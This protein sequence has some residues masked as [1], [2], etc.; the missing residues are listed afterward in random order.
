MPWFQTWFTTYLAARLAPADV[1]A[2]LATVPT[3]TSGRMLLINGNITEWISYT[4]VSGSTITGLTRNLSTTADPV[5]WGTGLDW[6]AGSQILMVVMHDQYVDKESAFPIPGFTTT[7]RDALTMSDPYFT[8]TYPLIYNTTAGQYQ[9]YNGSAWTTFATGTVADATDLIGGKVKLSTADTGN[10]GVV[11]NSTDDRYIALAGTS[12][13]P[14]VTNKYVTNDDTATAATAGKLARRLA[15]GNITVITESQANNS[16]NAAST[17][18]VDA[19]LSAAIPVY[20]NGSTTFDLSTAT[21]TQAIAHW[22]WKSPKYV[23]VKWI[24][25]NTTSPTLYCE[26]VYNWTTQTSNCLYKNGNPSYTMETNFRIG[27]GLDATTYQTGVITYDTTNINIAWTKT[28]SP[29]GT[30][31][32]F[33]EAYA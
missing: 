8:G 9:Y 17:A 30:L 10:T 24:I 3:P 18:Y 26:A 23:R 27:N 5:T 7:Q 20:K 22:C 1:V 11:L 4:G 29:T 2:T 19:W 6:G 25:L 21:G 14:S 32:L 28:G 33:W 16:T 31:T 15:G 13:T 12:G